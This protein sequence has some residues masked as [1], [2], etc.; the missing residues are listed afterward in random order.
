M[1][2]LGAHKIN[3]AAVGNNFLFPCK[4]CD[5]NKLAMETTS[6]GPDPAK[7]SACRQQE[8]G[9]PSESVFMEIWGSAG[10]EGRTRVRMDA[11]PGYHRLRAGG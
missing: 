7:R 4:H 3:V 2:H 8:W 10:A 1:R 6:S 5:S 9:F 11:L